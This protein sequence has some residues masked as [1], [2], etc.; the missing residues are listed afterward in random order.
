[1]KIPDST[2]VALKNPVR[3]SEKKVE[4]VKILIWAES[5]FKLSQIR[6]FTILLSTFFYPTSG[7]GL[8]FNSNILP[9]NQSSALLKLLLPRAFWMGYN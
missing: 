2:E 6:L 1:M 5:T 8:N 4:I 9:S 3:L 7:F